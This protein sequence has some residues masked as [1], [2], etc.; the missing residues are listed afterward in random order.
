VYHVE[1][2]VAVI[3]GDLCGGCKTCIALCPYLAITADDEKRIAVVES[4]LCKGCGTCAAACPA[5]AAQQQ[6]YTDRQVMAEL[7]GALAAASTGGQQQE[8]KTEG[9]D[10]A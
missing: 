8:Q 4:A 6:G 7:A 9:T 2:I 1:P 3:D 10:R 5:G